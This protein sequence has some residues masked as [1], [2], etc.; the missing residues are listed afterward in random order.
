MSNQ[1]TDTRTDEEKFQ[2]NLE[3]ILNSEFNQ[4][5]L[6]TNSLRKD[7]LTGKTGSGIGENQYAAIMRSEDANKLRDEIY[8]S[9]KAR[10][11]RL[12][13]ADTAQRPSD[14][15]I[16]AYVLQNINDALENLELGRLE[17][18]AK[19]KSGKL[20]FEVPENLK[21]LSYREIISKYARNREIKLE[22]LNKDEQTAVSLYNLLTETYK[23][24][25]KV[26]FLRENYLEGINA[27]G[28]KLTEEYSPKKK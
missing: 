21:T 19:D 13:V 26:D 4:A 10:Y 15:Q 16:S 27:T 1:E 5:V 3:S 17:Q 9:E 8:E 14:A 23:F 18:I 6:A 28:K 11:E 22:D 7:P 2:D 20:D 24:S 12:G 25:V